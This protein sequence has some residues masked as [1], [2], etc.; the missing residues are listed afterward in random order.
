MSLKHFIHFVAKKI[1]KCQAAVACIIIRRRKKRVQN[2]WDSFYLCLSLSDYLL[3]VTYRSNQNNLKIFLHWYSPTQSKYSQN[4]KPQVCKNVWPSKPRHL[5]RHI[6]L[7]APNFYWKKIEATRLW[8]LLTKGPPLPASRP[9]IHLCFVVVC[10]SKFKISNSCIFQPV[11]PSLKNVVAKAIF[12]LSISVCIPI[13]FCFGSP[14]SYHYVLFSSDWPP[15]PYFNKTLLTLAFILFM[16]SNHQTTNFVFPNI[17]HK[18]LSV[19]AV[20]KE[21]NFL[22]VQNS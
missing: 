17:F 3:T 16:T 6:F 5:T 13:S 1:N 8:L 22:L 12:T 11:S 2:Y 20:E 14:C 7:I 21:K 18:F 19:L 15:C 10:Q 9:L 4:L